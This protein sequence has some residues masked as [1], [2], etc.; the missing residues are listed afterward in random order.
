MIDTLAFGS[1]AGSQR[2]PDARSSCTATPG[3]RSVSSTSR[4]RPR[5]PGVPAPARPAPISGD[6]D[7][8]IEVDRLLAQVIEAHGGLDRWSAVTGISA[9]MTISGPFW[10]SK[11]QPGVLGEETV[12]LDTRREHIGFT[13]FGGAD[14]TLELGVDPEHVVVRDIE[15]AVVQ[16][17]TAARASFAGFGVT[18][19]WDMVQTGYFIGYAIW[20][21]LTE[22]FLLSYPGI[23]AHEIEP[24]EEN[25][26]T[27][28]RLY[29]T[30]PNSIATHNPVQV[31]YFDEGS[32]QRRMDYAPEVNGNALV[33]H[34]TDEPKTFGGIVV[35][36]CHRVR[37]RLEDG[38]ANLTID[39][40]TIDIHDVEYRAS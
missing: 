10:E 9:H 34:Y 17:R 36:T 26:E 14:W 30:F 35:P 37:R 39:L 20:N 3:T 4:L 22:P 23:E 6:Y 19:Q 31:F 11:G 1:Y 32:M 28:R 21:Y 13:P 7:K 12:E 38:T 8:E 29:V 2:L 40:I 18:S 25:G 33:A 27:W 24:W 15:G 5:G 16:E